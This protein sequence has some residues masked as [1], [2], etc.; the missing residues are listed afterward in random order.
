MYTPKSF[1]VQDGAKLRQFV[2]RNPFAT[3]VSS[4]GRGLFASHIPL[5]IENPDGAPARLAGHLARAN[6]QW[7]DLE[8]EHEVLL[9]FHGP[10][11][12]ISPLW[13]QA[14]EAVPT[15]NYAAVHIYGRPVIMN[16]P[17]RT[18]KIVEAL[19]A[20]FEGLQWEALRARWSEGFL[21]KMLQGIVAFE[22][23]VTRLEGKFKL[24]QNR[25]TEDIAGTHAA[26]QKSADPGARL[27]AEFME[28][29]GIL[30]ESGSK[31]TRGAV[32]HSPKS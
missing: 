1:A 18:R 8:N 2:E 30:P 21:E 5:R 12:Y 20:Q 16:D 26:L 15:W 19:T 6:P 25:R 27:L 3:L 31:V 9:I 4:T 32:D 17:V 29:E 28:Q 11:A 14:G 22:I 24:G 10:H 23:E 7:H 13:Y